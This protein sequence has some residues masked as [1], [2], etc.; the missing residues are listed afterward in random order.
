MKL[1]MA[2]SLVASWLKH[3]KHCQIVQTNWKASP[4]WTESVNDAKI[5][6]LC[7]AALKFFD[8]K[9]VFIFGYAAGKHVDQEL[10][11]GAEGLDEGASYSSDLED[12]GAVGQDEDLRSDWHKMLGQTECDIVGVSYEHGMDKPV[13]YAAESAFH[14]AG[15]Q[16]SKKNKGLSGLK[17]KSETVTA[18]N[19]ALK[20]F[21]NSLSMYRS[22]GVKNAHIVFIAPRSRDV[23]EKEVIACCSLVKEFFSDKEFSFSY[24]LYLE[25]D[26][27][28]DAACFESEVLKPIL[29]ASTIVDDTSELFLRSHQL[30]EKG[31]SL[32]ANIL[33]EVRKLLG[34]E[35]MDE[36]RNDMLGTPADVL[37]ALDL[38]GGIIKK[39]TDDPKV[40]KRQE[41]RFNTAS[42]TVRGY[43]AVLHG[44]EN[45]PTQHD[46][47]EMSKPH[48]APVA[49]GNKN[50]ADQK[51][52]GFPFSAGYKGNLKVVMGILNVQDEESLA[53][54]VP[55]KTKLKIICRK[56]MDDERDQR[57]NHSPQMALRQFFSARNGLDHTIKLKEM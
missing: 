52:Q 43:Y 31:M 5:E 50:V 32:H 53:K 22:F 56:V 37:A 10:D 3:V 36:F 54:L 13:L 35:T 23:V 55:T 2:E 44:L 48:V 15:L 47:E 41:N 39:P 25:H 1:E 19:V 11:Q 45:V 57:R 38:L 20:M 18:W 28:A 9:K 26:N 21:K 7:Q 14:R 40:T 34:A 30:L 51:V 6:E 12:Q 8:E 24:D 46:L 29:V 49:D 16:Y 17:L 33:V 42:G 27:G 4:D